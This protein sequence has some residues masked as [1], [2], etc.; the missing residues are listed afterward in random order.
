MRLW[1]KIFSLWLGFSFVV[2]A[3]DFQSDM[4]IC[5]AKDKAWTASA[6]VVK[7]KKLGIKCGTV[8]YNLMSDDNRA[9]HL[10]WVKDKY[11]DENL[12]VILVLKFEDKKTKADNVLRMIQA[13][14]FDSELQKLIAKIKAIGKPLVVRPLHEVDGNWHPWGMYA[15]GNSPELA[16]GA[17]LHIT[18]QFAS[19]KDLVKIDINFNRKD[20]NQRVLGEADFYIPRL[21]V[22]VDS[23][24]ISTYNRCGTSDKYLT[25]RSFA[26]DFRPVYARLRQLT[27]KSIY[28]AETSTSGLCGDRLPWFETM[29]TS[30]KTEFP[31]VK[32][33]TFFF[34]NVAVG[35]A[36]NDVPI[37][38][39]LDN[40]EQEKLFKNLLQ[41]YGL[42]NEIWLDEG[43]SSFNFRAPWNLNAGLMYLFDEIPNPALNPVTGESFGREGLVFST[44]FTQRL[45]FPVGA[46]FEAGPTVKLGV[47]QSNNQNQ[48]WS[49]RGYG[50]VSLGLFKDL[51]SGPIKWGQ[52]GVELF[53]EY[54][55][56]TT[57]VPDRY[58]G[59]GESRFG[60]RTTVNFGGDWS[61]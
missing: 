22:A 41:R 28:I 49:N 15:K 53:G 29:L 51:R 14:Y 32:G 48:W 21:D 23:Y 5:L 11:L 46:G 20:A 7:M 17:I 3:D 19:V 1:S 38:W 34:G 56:Y 24:S 6:H 27:D 4:E 54:R 30:L 36:S 9:N 8:Y 16:V 13:G 43:L 10:G 25:E 59:D 37:Q 57:P 26:D 33:V 18:K 35:E 50:S 58:S 31:K 40:E 44:L 61:Q 39:G 45:L 52:W 55:Q 2:L 47:I 42:V 12:D 60:I